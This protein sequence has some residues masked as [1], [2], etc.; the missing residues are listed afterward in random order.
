MA[1]SAAILL[2][3][4]SPCGLGCSVFTSYIERGKWVADQ[5]DTGM[6]F[7]DHPSCTAPELPFGN[8]KCSGS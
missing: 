2:A 8:V 7:I 4:D 3:N 5:I 1:T 6:V